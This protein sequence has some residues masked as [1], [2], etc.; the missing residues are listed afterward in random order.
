MF[1][2]FISLF[3]KN[4]EVILA[5][6]KPTLGNTWRA[7]RASSLAENKGTKQSSHLYQDTN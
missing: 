7:N 6:Q 3:F 5:Y 4:L 2:Y 1:F